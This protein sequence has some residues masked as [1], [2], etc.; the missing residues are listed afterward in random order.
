IINGSFSTKEKSRHLIS[1][2]VNLLSTKLELGS[3]MISLYLLNN[4]DHYTSHYF[5]PFY[6]RT[7]VS[8]ARS[9]FEENDATSE[10]KVI[11]TK[12]WGKIIGL[13]SSLDY[14]HR[15]I[16]HAHYNLDD[17]ICSFY[18]AA[19]NKSKE[20][21]EHEPGLMSLRSSK[22]SRQLLFLPG[23]P[24]VD[25]HVVATR[26]D[27]SMTVPN[28]VGS[29][30]RPDKDD[31]EYYCCTMLILFCPWQSGEDL[32]NKNQS[33]HE[34]FEAYAFSDQS[35]L[36]MK[37][38]N[39]RFECL[40]A[41]DDFR[42]QL[43]SG[44]LDITK[45]PSS[46]PIQLHEDLVNKLDGSQ[47]DM[48]S[49]DMEEPG[50]SYDQY[51]QDKKGPFFLKRESAMKAMKDILFNIGWVTPLTGN[52]QPKPIPIYTPI[53]LPYEKPQHWDLIL[54]AMRDH[55]LAAHEKSRGLPSADN[56]TNKN[57]EPGKYRPNIVE[58]CDKYYFD[59]LGLEYGS[60]KE[61]TLNIVKC[62]NLNNEQERAFRIIAQH[63]ACSVSEPLQMYIGGMGG[64]GK[65]QVIKALLQFFAD[66]NSSF[67]IVTSAPTGNAAAL[68]GGST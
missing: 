5:I 45:L 23:H 31:R 11:L 63:S 10:P 50:H 52:I 67:A 36:D 40:D 7:Y 16:Q 34:A 38:M 68:L 66:R 44:K 13:S 41:C 4:P 53:Q 3:P 18:K 37:N 60:I 65:S 29:L 26:R 47:L 55:V 1:R 28:F 46:I 14:T 30:P 27:S 25:T 35:L 22:C 2:I 21:I 51:T 61:L 24:L 9:V 64:T 59:K 15:P 19:K 6:W 56:D 49:S 48:N 42:A 62:H 32:K 57:S 58:I 39:I 8:T 20:D 17:W 12:R 43:K 54:K 33:W